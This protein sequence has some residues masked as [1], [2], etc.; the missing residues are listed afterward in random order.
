VIEVVEPSPS[1]AAASGPPSWLV[2]AT[3]GLTLLCL[4]MAVA[5]TT[6]W[7]HFLVDRGELISLI[8]LA[9]ILFAGLSL[10]RQRRLWASLPLVLPWVLYPVVTQG[11]QLIDNLTI[12]QMRLITHI[13]LALLFGAPVAVI[14]LATGQTL[15][16]IRS[17]SATGDADRASN[18]PRRHWWTALVPGLRLIAIGRAREGGAVLA[19]TLFVLEIVVAHVY[20]GTLMVLTL[21]VIMLGTLGYLAGAL[22][23]PSGSS[24]W[25]DTE[26]ADRLALIV[27]IAG[28]TVSLGLYAG[29][30]NRPGA[31]QGSPHYYH[32]PSQR[33]ASY[34]T[35]AT[36]VPPGE[37]T[38][39]PHGVLHEAG[40]VLG[41]YG[42]VL[43]EL[44]SAYYVM[45]RNYNYW[46]HNELFLRNTPVLAGFRELSLRRIARAARSAEA[47]NVH[48]TRLLQQLP[49]EHALAALVT[50]AQSYV[51][52]NLRR[53]AILEQMS[54]EFQKTK[55]GLQ[56]A[57]HLYEGE[58]KV[59]G[60]V[61]DD[62]LAKH[63]RT[64]DAPTTAVA[65]VPFVERGRRIRDLYANRIVGF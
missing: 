21:A 29:Y 45:D 31:Y 60:A 23:S 24:R 53:A 43:T 19:L 10:H 44:V 51:A 39:L 48:A 1:R 35:D 65:T 62:L 25:L 15:T 49:R 6:L 63:R 33:D 18:R 5:E 7:I 32:D 55:A 54:G 27:L 2:L 42:T 59:I 50:E 22:R 40:S 41:E 56:H 64:V 20:L 47:A 26:R 38:P 12:D 13:I 9:F 17:R 28:V 52:F 30:R 16:K 46:F 37:I 3:I 57:T 11:D 61:L 8:G 36:V 34:K 4:L 14:V 58:G